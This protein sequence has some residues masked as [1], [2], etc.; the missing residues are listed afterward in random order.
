MALSKAKLWVTAKD[1]IFIT[2]GIAL[3]AFGFSAFIFPEKVV[4]GGLAGVGTIIYF[5][6]DIPVAVSQFGINMALLMM[7][8]RIVG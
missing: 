5:L 2:L 3:Y 1:Y 6:T 4:I 7:A 8:Y